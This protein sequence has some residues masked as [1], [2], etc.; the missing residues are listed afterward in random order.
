M[1]ESERAIAR[2]CLCK[3]STRIV[4]STSTSARD[5]AAFSRPAF[6]ALVR[7]CARARALVRNIN[8]QRRALKNMEKREQTQV[9]FSAAVSQYQI[10]CAR[11]PAFCASRFIQ[12][13]E[14]C[15]N[16]CARRF[17]SRCRLG[18]YARSLARSLA[19]FTLSSRVKWLGNFAPLL[20]IVVVV[21]EFIRRSFAND[22]RRASYSRRWLSVADGRRRRR[23]TGAR[24]HGNGDERAGVCV[25]TSTRR[26]R[27][28]RPLVIFNGAR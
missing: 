27:V 9:G 3:F 15:D 20:V 14:R 8:V 24:A 25:L 13:A 28:R 23:S 5:W 2:G 7:S 1:S 11:A 19:F 22:E 4:A 10:V 26:K 21:V 16:F 17:S 6:L 12:R 18:A